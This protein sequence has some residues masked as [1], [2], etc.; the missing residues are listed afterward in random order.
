MFIKSCMKF[1]IKNYHIATIILISVFI[2][3]YFSA[4]QLDVMG[5]PIIDLGLVLID[6]NYPRCAAPGG[7]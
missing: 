6:V 5:N 2:A 4:K 1:L 3:G 7:C